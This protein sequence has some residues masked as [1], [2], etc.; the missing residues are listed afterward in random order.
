MPDEQPQEKSSQ[1]VDPQ[2]AGWAEQLGVTPQD[3]RSALEEFG[4][5]VL[6]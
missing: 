4:P 3:L 6:D 5:L 2:L 1:P